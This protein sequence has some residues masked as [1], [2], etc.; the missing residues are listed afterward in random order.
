MVLITVFVI[1][2]KTIELSSNIAKCK[3]RILPKMTTQRK[4][5]AESPASGA[6]DKWGIKGWG[7]PL[8]VGVKVLTF[9][10]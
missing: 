8:T 1:K 5:K 3:K 7:R 2:F 6:G 9:Q 4:D 10:S